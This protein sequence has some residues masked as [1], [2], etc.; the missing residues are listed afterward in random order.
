MSVKEIIAQSGFKFNKRYGQNFITDTNMLRAIVAD[1]GITKNDAVLEIG[2][3]AGTLTICL[4][5]RASKVLSYEI[6]PALSPILQDTLK[7]F[8]NIEVV[9]KD[10]MEEDSEVIRHKLGDNFAVVA[11]LPY[12]ITTPVIMRLVEQGL[13]KSITIMVQDEVAERLTSPPGAKEYGAI[14]AQIELVARARLMRKVSR[15][16]FFPSPNVDS[17]VVRIDITDKY[18]SE[19]VR[20]AKPLIAA[21]FAMR[22]KTLVNNIVRG[23]GIARE[24]AETSLIKA[25]LSTSI[26]GEMLSAD[27]FIQLA[28]IIFVEVND[29]NTDKAH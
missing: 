25:G 11:N 2:A 21:A 17:A 13:G 4:A 9:F 22:R 19:D 5:E 16:M 8:D 10:F 23:L 29:E 20:R 18:P 6:D 15:N 1:S 26:R 7:G 28:R 27:Q 3:G 12:Y 14:T 24:R